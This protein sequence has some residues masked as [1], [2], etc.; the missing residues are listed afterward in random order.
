MDIA[1]IEGNL[2]LV[3]NFILNGINVNE[4]YNNDNTALHIISWN[5]N[6]LENDQCIEIAEILLENGAF[7]NAQNDIGMTPLNTACINNKMK[8]AKKLLLHNADIS[9]KNNRNF[10]P[11][12][13]N[14]FDGHIEIAKIILGNGVKVNDK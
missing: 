3:K 6:I 1:C 12:Y 11:L 14:C 2:E 4:K 8:L 7:I 10:T 13:Y 5:E 9:I